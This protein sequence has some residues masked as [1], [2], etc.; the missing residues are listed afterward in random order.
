VTVHVVASPCSAGTPR[1]VLAR[2][3]EKAREYAGGKVDDRTSV[4]ALIDREHEPAQQQEADQAQA[5]ARHS[6]AVGVAL[7]KPCYEVWTLLHLVD[8]GR[9]FE[10]CA[11]VCK[12]LA[13]EWLANFDADFDLK[14]QA[15]YSKLMPLRHEAAKRAEKHRKLDDGCWTEVLH[16][17]NEIDAYATASPALPDP[18]QASSFP[19]SADKPR[20]RR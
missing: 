1:A 19:P 15:D 20:Y 9:A 10:D 5:A 6:S 12:T 3:Q 18:G 7:S 2:A 16:V 13:Q 17:V 14:A 11:T 4:W 8:T